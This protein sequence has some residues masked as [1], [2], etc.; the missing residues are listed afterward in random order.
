MNAAPDGDAP[1]LR[2]IAR[3]RILST[4]LSDYLINSGEPGVLLTLIRNPGAAIAHDAFYRLAEHATH[5]RAL[6]APLATRADL[7]PPVAFE[8]FWHVP[9]ELRRFILSR[10][11]TDSEMLNRILRITLSSPGDAGEATEARFPPREAIDFAVKL[12]GELKLDDAASSFAAMANIAPETAL[13]ILSDRE[14]EPMTV[15]LKVLGCTRARFEEAMT[16]LRHSDSGLIRAERN[17]EELQAIFDGL[18]FNKARILLTYWD[19]F[20]RKAGPYSPHN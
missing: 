16:R 7:P 3:R 18:S 9:Q 19:W 14:G 12:A 10:F 4:V 1:K 17:L 6:L 5:H 15:L 8:L 11:L 20:V 13:R 2:M